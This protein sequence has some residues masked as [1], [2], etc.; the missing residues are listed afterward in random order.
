MDVKMMMIYNTS[1][2]F[3]IAVDFL[4]LQIPRVVGR[5]A[6]APDRLASKANVDI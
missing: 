4:Y 1:K 5:Y 2:S 6:F 3:S